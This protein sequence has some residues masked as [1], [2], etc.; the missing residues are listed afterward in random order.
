MPHMENKSA[1]S[2]M[3]HILAAFR[4]AY[5]SNRNFLAGIAK[6]L[7]RNPQ[8]VVTVADDFI[9]FDDASIAEA[10]RSGFDGIITVRPRTAAAESAIVRS[11]LPMAVLG[12]GSG[13]CSARRHNIA[14]IRGKDQTIGDVAAAHFISLG[15]FRSYA[16]VD[17]GGDVS[18]S[19][20]RFKGFAARLRRSGYAVARISSRFAAGSPDDIRFLAGRLCSI[21][22]PAAVMAAF[23][24]RALNVLTACADAGIAVPQQVAVVGVDDDR[25]LCDFSRPSLTSINTHQERK[26]EAAAEELDRLMARKL[27]PAKTV[28]VSGA[29]VVMRESTNFTSPSAGLVERALRFIED[30]AVS[31]IRA[32]DV[33]AHLGV[34]RALAD[35]RFRECASGTIGEA[36]TKVRIAEV[37]RLLRETNMPIARITA[38]CGFADDNYAKRLFRN[39]EGMAMRDWRRGNVF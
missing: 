29:D 12:T 11:S 31:G 3:R 34:S 20:G 32:R 21:P 2:R 27:S 35:R 13:D 26:G 17:A 30:N 36:I 10:E 5:Q 6:H 28:F 7:K 37:K 14:L 24:N 4:L 33:V 38:L 15:N 16:F 23:D 18:W 19:S 1:K 8:W 25:I 22:K 39:T 9:D